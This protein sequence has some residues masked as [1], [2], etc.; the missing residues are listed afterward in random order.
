MAP[1]VDG[2]GT[3]Q[4][5]G[6]ETRMALLEASGRVFSR[7]TYDQ[8]KLKDISDEANASQGSIYF[9]FGN[10]YDIAEAVLNVQQ[11]RMATTLEAEL[12][13][14]RTGYDT[15]LHMLVKLAT[16]MATDPLVQAGLQ[17]VDSLPEELRDRGHD[18][19]VRWQERTQ[20][21]VEQGVRDGSITSTETP[22]LLAE[23]ITALYV[24]GQ[25]MSGMADR[26]TSLPARMERSL[27]FV[28]MLLRPES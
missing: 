5:R 26:W 21:L 19:Y 17:L 11:E 25:M 24:G 4:Q 15:I 8:A 20:M 9:H 3:K 13:L 18:S 6:I 1:H 2:A 22:E 27:P 23:I 10:K 12:S 7:L 28:R 16:L 14:G